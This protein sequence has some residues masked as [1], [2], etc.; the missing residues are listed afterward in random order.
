[1]PVLCSSR[2]GIH[3]GMCAIQLILASTSP[4]RRE[5]LQ[6]TGLQFEVVSPRFVEQP[7][8]LSPA[9]EALFNAQS[10]AES[11]VTDFPDALI[12][13]ADTIVVCFGEKMGKPADVCEAKRMLQKLSG[14]EHQVLT[15]CTLLNRKTSKCLTL[16]EI[17]WVTFKTLTGSDIET[18]VATGEPLDKSGAYGIQGK[19]AGFISSIQG[20][21]ETVIGLPTTPLLKLLQEFEEVDP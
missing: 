2:C 9:K 7:T 5:L 18:Y 15:A 3:C 6:K 8:Q 13:G 21:I 10:K 4:R 14:R 16:L 1:M 12:L 19:A 11:I 20:D 17:A